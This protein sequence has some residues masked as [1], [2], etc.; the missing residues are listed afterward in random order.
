MVTFLLVC[1]NY[2]LCD[3]ENDYNPFPE[4]LSLEVLKLDLTEKAWE[5]VN[6]LSGQTLIICEGRCICLPTCGSRAMF[7][8]NSIVFDEIVERRFCLKIYDFE[9]AQT[10][11]LYQSSGKQLLS[12][13]W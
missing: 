4:R 9:T 1:S 11:L 13:L 2:G 8:G 3:M 10:E 6:D 7:K 12:L 5:E